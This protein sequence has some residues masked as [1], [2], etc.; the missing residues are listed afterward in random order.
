MLKLWYNYEDFDLIMQDNDVIKG[1]RILITGGTGSFGSTFMQILLMLNPSEIIIFSRDELKQFEIRNRFDSSLLRFVI[2]DVRDRDVVNHAMKG[3][4]YVFSAAALKQVPTC[5]FFPMEAVK[6]NI[7]GAH[8]V[9]DAAIKNNVKKLVILSTDKAVYPINA[10]G[11]SK[12]LMEKVMIASARELSHFGSKTV[13]CGVRYGNVMHSRGSVIPYF[14]TLIKQ[15]KKLRI[16]DPKMTRF[17]LPLRYS[18]KLVLHALSDG[19]NGNIYVKKAPAANMETLAKAI[20]K[21]FNYSKGFEIVGVR[22][23]EKTHETLI[24]KEELIRAKDQGDFYCIPP[25]TSNLDYDK[26]FTKGKRDHDKN[27]GYTSKNTQRLTVDETAK[28]LLTLPEIQKDLKNW[29]K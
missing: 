10:M 9:I 11:M 6:T 16:T 28:L 5:E 22:A 12:A 14:I 2:G 7:L 24:A 25:E 20:C 3:V 1:K 26:Y 17:L 8:N 4:D 19:N 23:G 15:N 18:V 29:K 13:L 21:I 27:E